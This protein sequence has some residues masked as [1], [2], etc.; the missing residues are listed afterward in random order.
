MIKIK[1]KKIVILEEKFK[2]K[3]KRNSNEKGVIQ[4]KEYQLKKKIKKTNII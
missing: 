3:I 1:N 4:G 2:Q